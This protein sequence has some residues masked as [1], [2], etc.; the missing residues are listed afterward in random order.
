MERQ[1]SVTTEV[2]ANE[3]NEEQPSTSSQACAINQQHRITQ[4]FSRPPPIHKK[5]KIDNLVLKMI[6]KGHHPFRLVEE[7]V[8]RKLIQEVSTCPGYTLPSRKTLSN[9]L[10]PSAHMKIL[11]EVKKKVQSATAVCL[12]TDGWTSKS[13]ISY[14]AVTVHYINAD[15]QLTS[16]L[17]SCGE[18][19]GRHTSENLYN[20]LKKVMVDFEIQNN[21]SA[22]VSDNAPNIVAAIRLE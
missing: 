1:A 2:D 21:V 4:F 11:E 6:A 19:G 3:H 14:V 15:T 16:N 9:N 20:F 18:F 22:V 17:L 5:Q 10:L 12:T 8:F 7:P 13:N